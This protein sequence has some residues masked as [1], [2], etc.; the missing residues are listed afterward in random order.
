MKL[1]NN[2]TRRVGENVRALLSNILLQKN[3][4]V[5]L[6][7]SMITITEVQPTSD[8]RYAKVFIS[9]MGKN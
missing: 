4:I 9:C 1:L 3:S 6:D 2:R 5:G 8:L 7:N